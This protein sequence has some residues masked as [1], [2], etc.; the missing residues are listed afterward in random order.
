MKFRLL[1]LLCWAVLVVLS[2]AAQTPKPQTRF[3]K[4]DGLRVHYD[5]YGKGP[6]GRKEAIVFVH[7]WT[8]NA[9]FWKA[10]VTAFIAQTRVIAIDLPGHGEGDTPDNVYYSIDFVA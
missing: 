1:A 3:A 5:D 4:L 6:N 8:C 10:N 2:L 7:G 9:T